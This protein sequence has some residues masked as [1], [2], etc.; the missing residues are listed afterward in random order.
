MTAVTE[1]RTMVKALRILLLSAGDGY[2]VFD[3]CKFLMLRAG[4]KSV[5]RM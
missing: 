5:R 2:C 1:A 4:A 3:N